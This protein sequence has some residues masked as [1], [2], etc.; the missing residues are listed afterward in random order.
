MTWNEFIE[1]TGKFYSVV[2]GCGYF[3]ANVLRTVILLL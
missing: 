3:A 1:K 2:V